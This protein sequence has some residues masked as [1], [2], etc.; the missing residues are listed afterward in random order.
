MLL[1]KYFCTGSAG[2]FKIC[3]PVLVVPEYLSCLFCSFNP[4]FGLT[5]NSIHDQRVG[6]ATLFALHDTGCKKTI[7][8]ISFQVTV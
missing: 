7:T 2:I 3:L 1:G 4:L 6:F 5:Q 8:E